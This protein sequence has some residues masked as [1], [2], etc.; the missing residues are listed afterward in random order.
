MTVARGVAGTFREAGAVLGLLVV[1]QA[2]TMLLAV[3]VFLLPQPIVI[4]Q[5]FA[6]NAPSRRPSR[7]PVL[8][9]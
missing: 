7:K 2:V 1:W 5:A 6:S 4:A 8:V 3:P 9:C